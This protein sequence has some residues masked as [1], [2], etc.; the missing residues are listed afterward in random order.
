[1]SLTGTAQE[2][3]LELAEAEISADDGIDK[4][5]VKLDKLYL[6]DAT[7][8]KFETLEVFDSFQRKSETSIHQ[9]KTPNRG[10]FEGSF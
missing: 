3:V 7:L 9:G 10:N 4:V 8:D 5:L 2:S 1:M 6:K